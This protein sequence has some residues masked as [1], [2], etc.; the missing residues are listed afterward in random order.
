M[1][2]AASGAPTSGTQPAEVEVVLHA[3]LT[4]RYPALARMSPETSLLGSGAIDSLGVLELMTFLGERFDIAIDDS[5]FDSEH[6]ASLANLVRFIV[7]R[8]GT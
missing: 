7:E 6:L 5:D 8:K 1:L 2:S 3:Y 4:Q